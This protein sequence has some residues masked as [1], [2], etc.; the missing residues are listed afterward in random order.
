MRRETRWSLLLP[1]C[2]AAVVATSVARAEDDKPAARTME[3]KASDALIYTNLKEVINHGANLYNSGD[4]NGCYR[5][6]EGALMNLKPMLGHRSDLQKA[7]ETG[8]AN[9]Q[10]DPMLYRRAFVLRTVLDQIRT[11]LRGNAP[12][13]KNGKEPPVVVDP[14]PKDKS[15]EPVVR[16]TPKTLWDRLGGE[17]GVTKIIDDFANAAT[18]DPKVDFLRHGKYK[19][20]AEQVVKMKR[21]LVEMVSQAAGGPFKYTGPDMKTVHKGMGITND[22]FDALAGHLKKALEKNKVAEKD[23]A[24][25]LGAV[26]ATR[27]QIVAPKKAD[28][29][30]KTEKKEDKKPVD[31]KDDKKPAGKSSVTGKVTYKGKPL[32]DGSV[33]LVSDGGV[34]V[35]A[36]I[37]A[38]GTYKAEG[39]K[40]GVYKVTI[41]PPIAAG[42]EEKKAKI[43]KIPEKFKRIKTTPLTYTVV[44]GRQNHDIDLQD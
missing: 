9:A 42:G 32:A 41:N 17:A 29:K 12:A 6:W 18:P 44:E 23:A 2:L 26:N 28:D 15:G 7:I 13:K 36:L 31:K 33:T 10:Q 19:L 30:P 8:L 20:T 34:I 38:D 16:P 40:P 22:Q 4:W 1:A 11:D 25:V 14:K 27:S 3:R 5:L 39:V 24:T 37:E 21:D 35:V 43:V